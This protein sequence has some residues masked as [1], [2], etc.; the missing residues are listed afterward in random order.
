MARAA[1][2]EEPLFRG[3]LW[4]YLRDRGWPEKRIFLTIAVLFW[5]GHL[6]YIAEA[7]ISFWFVVPLGSTLL[8]FVAWR[9][10]TIT[11]TM[12]AHAL[13]NAVGDMVGHFRW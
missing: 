2:T 11:A 10:R 1:A 8:A 4:G 13:L 5:I 9:S 6:Y 3:F 7:P 12:T